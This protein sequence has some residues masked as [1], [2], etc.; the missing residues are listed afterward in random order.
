MDQKSQLLDA[1]TC[2]GFT[3]SKIPAVNQCL[4]YKCFHYQVLWLSDLK[5]LVFLLFN[6]DLSF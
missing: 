5:H 4:I 2:A 6:S 3:H 1:K